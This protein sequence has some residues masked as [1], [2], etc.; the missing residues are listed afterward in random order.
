MIAQAIGLVALYWVIRTPDVISTISGGVV[1]GFRWLQSSR[2]IG[3]GDPAGSVSL[4]AQAQDYLTRLR[5]ENQWTYPTEVQPGS[6]LTDE[7][8]EEL[9]T[10][11][12]LF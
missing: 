10:L 11:A 9:R 4:F 2:G 12:G 1:S 6:E 8:L 7:Q 3:S 5:A